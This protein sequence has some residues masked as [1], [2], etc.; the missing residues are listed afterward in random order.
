MSDAHEPENANDAFTGTNWVAVGRDC[1]N[2]GHTIRTM[3]PAINP[4]GDRR[5]ECA[6]CEK[7]N[8]VTAEHKLA[9]QEGEA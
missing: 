1:R 2:C 7:P 9:N 8:R 5:V 3:V 4:G 6:K